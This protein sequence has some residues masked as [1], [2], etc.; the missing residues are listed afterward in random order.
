M[1]FNEINL[2]GLYVA[3]IMLIML[4]DPR[5]YSIAVRQA[6]AAVEQARANAENANAEMIRREK[7]NEIAVTMEERQT[8]ISQATS[9]AA[10]Y[11]SALANLE[12][13]RI[14]LKR[15]EVRSPVNGYVANLSAQLGD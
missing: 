14:N 9:A 5:N 13:A 10:S 3:P 6:Q 8:Y 7:L 2:F 1:R 4:I 12:Q 11:Q 15:T